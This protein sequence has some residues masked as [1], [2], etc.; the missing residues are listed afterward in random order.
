M[1]AAIRLPVLPL[2]GGC[3]CGAVRYRVAGR[4][5]TLY[6]CHCTDCQRQSGSAFGLSMIVR[7]EDLSAAG[8]VAAFAFT[9]ATG[10]VSDRNFC[11][12][13]GTRLWH[14]R[15]GGTRVSVKA[16]TLDDA[17]WLSPAAHIWTASRQTW[18]ALPDDI[19]Q[20]PGQPDMEALV[21]AFAARL[22]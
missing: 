7:T 21:E 13:C 10:G 3:Q 5:L 8:D 11:P 14:R 19:L 20:F 9:N 17:G 1:P 15:Q 12:A 16:G 6:A 4:P 22:A 2:E 18:V